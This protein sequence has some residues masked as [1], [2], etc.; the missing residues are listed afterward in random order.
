MMIVEN[1][2]IGIPGCAGNT[3]LVDGFLGNLSASL[4]FLVISSFEI[5]LSLPEAKLCSSLGGIVVE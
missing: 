2:P 5:C 3:I 4:E 1:I